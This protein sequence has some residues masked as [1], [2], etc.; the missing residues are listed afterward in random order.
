MMMDCA[1]VKLQLLANCNDGD[2]GQG[3]DGTQKSKVVVHSQCGLGGVVRPPGLEPGSQ[4]WKAWIITPR[5]R[6]QSLKRMHQWSRFKIIDEVNPRRVSGRLASCWCS[7]I[8]IP[9]EF[10]RLVEGFYPIERALPLF[11]S[12][13]SVEGCHPSSRIIPFF[14]R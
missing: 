3:S 14:L 10:G 8:P 7:G 9:V 2:I 6:S 11:P 4:A 12:T 13:E 5:Q 1:P